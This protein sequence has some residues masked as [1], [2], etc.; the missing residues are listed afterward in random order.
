LSG[1]KRKKSTMKKG[2]TNKKRRRYESK[3]DWA[4]VGARSLQQEPIWPVRGGNPKKRIGSKNEASLDISK[5]IAS[6]HHK[7]G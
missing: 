7:E 3:W 5:S 4:G 6:S 1:E 2:K